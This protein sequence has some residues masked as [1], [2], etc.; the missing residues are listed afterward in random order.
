MLSGVLLVRHRRGDEVLTAEDDEL[1]CGWFFVSA[2]AGAAWA[3]R[4]GPLLIAR[5]A[6]PPFVGGERG[7]DGDRADA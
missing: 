5:N 2:R 7:V 4:G 3:S 1:A 6:D